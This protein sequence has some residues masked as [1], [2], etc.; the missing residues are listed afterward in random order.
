MATHKSASAN[1]KNQ[2][3]IGIGFSIDQASYNQT[4]QSLKKLQNI[5]QDD[6]T[7]KAYGSKGMQNQINR[8]K[9]S[10]SEV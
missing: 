7:G 8:I 2:I 5:T 3:N 6:I 1:G 10:A 9:Q 4:L